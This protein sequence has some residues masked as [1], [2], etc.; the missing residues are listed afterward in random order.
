M[1]DRYMLY[2]MAAMIGHISMETVE[3]AHCVGVLWRRDR[4]RVGVDSG[5]ETE[6]KYAWSGANKDAE[7]YGRYYA[8][9]FISC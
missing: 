9:Q 4:E 2:R 7:V 8:F 3:L 1:A 5:R 6:E